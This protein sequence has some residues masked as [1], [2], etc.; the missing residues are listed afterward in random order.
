MKM[1]PK[2]PS[3]GKRIRPPPAYYLFKAIRQP[4]ETLAVMHYCLHKDRGLD[5]APVWPD[6][7]TFPFGTY[8]FDALL[9]TK[10]AQSVAWMLIN[11]PNLW[12]GRV[13]TSVLNFRFAADG[14]PSMMWT[15]N[16]ANEQAAKMLR[17]NTQAETQS[18]VQGGGN[19][20]DI[21]HAMLGKYDKPAERRTA[22]RSGIQD[23][24][25]G[26]GSSSISRRAP[27]DDVMASASHPDS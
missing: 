5:E 7:V 10:N 16:K 14:E 13:L 3:K 20:A 11:Y 26:V 23:D 6:A 27:P 2:E 1:Y 17:E 22:N 9:A 21:P 4:E 12:S 18:A 24:A 8:C 15:V 25:P 19:S